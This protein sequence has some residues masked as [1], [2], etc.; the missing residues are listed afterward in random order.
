[1]FSR[2]FRSRPLD[3]WGVAPEQFEIVVVAIGFGKDMED[4]IDEV[5]DDPGRVLETAASKRPLPQLLAVLDDLLRDGAN[6]ALRGSCS[7][8]IG[9]ASCR[10]RV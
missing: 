7:D 1:M 9:R 10:E 6:L 5:D 8:Q 2:R 3:A 4:D